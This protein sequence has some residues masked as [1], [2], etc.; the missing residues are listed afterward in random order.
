MPLKTDR[1]LIAEKDYSE[2][3]NR[4]TGKIFKESFKVPEEMQEDF[5]QDAFFSLVRAVDGADLK[6]KFTSFMTIFH[7]HLK[8]LVSDY[9]Y[10]INRDINSLIYV[11]KAYS[12]EEF[13]TPL[14][15]MIFASSES[16]DNNKE[17]VRYHPEVATEQD[18]DQVLLKYNQFKEKL[19]PMHLEYL[20]GR[21]DSIP[22]QELADKLGVN[23]RKTDN[24]MYELF[25][26]ISEEFNIDYRGQR[27]PWISHRAIREV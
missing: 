4:Y 15:N 7:Y 17:L 10:N 26:S 19:K 13:P 8:D 23:P 12:D 3:Y 20:E 24:L 14:E 16:T 11:D 18:H 27:D 6:R 22:R 1:E 5:R 9:R 21:E 25:A 2:L